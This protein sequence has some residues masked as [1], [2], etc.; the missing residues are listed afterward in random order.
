MERSKCSRGDEISQG[1]LQVQQQVP[2]QAPFH[3]Q[4]WCRGVPVKTYLSF[5][6]KKKKPISLFGKHSSS[7]YVF[8][9]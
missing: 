9:F 7:G 4:E 8:V 1:H 2:G 6:Y 5:I 3:L